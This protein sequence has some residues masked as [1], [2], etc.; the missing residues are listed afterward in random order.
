MLDELAFDVLPVVK[1]KG[2]NPKLLDRWPDEKLKRLVYLRENKKLTWD[3]IS[4]DL[5]MSPSACHRRYWEIV[6]A[7]P[8]PE[9]AK[10]PTIRRLYEELGIRTFTIWRSVPVSTIFERRIPITLSAGIP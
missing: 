1:G 2:G 5:E 7:R 10:K 9:P 6:A 4:T 8:A 3:R